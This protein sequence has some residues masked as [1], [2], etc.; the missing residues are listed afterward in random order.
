MTHVKIVSEMLI[1]FLFSFFL[2]VDHLQW[3]F[4]CREP[5]AE[6]CRVL[7]L[8]QVTKRNTS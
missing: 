5:A 3:I 1:V 8:F 7:S 2:L 6:P 4:C